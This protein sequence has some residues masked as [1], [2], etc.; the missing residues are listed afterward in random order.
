MK[1]SKNVKF[2]LLI[3]MTLVMFFSM[4]SNC[5]RT[6]PADDTYNLT[7]GI[8]GEG[9]V[10]PG[11]GTHKIARDT[12]VELTVN[13]S[14]GWEFDSWT[15]T[16]ADDVI[17]DGDIY[18][19]N[20]NSNKSITARFINGDSIDVTDFLVLTKGGHVTGVD[21]VSIGDPANILTKDINLLLEK[22]DD[23][24]SDV[25][26]PR[27]IDNSNIVSDFYELSADKFFTTDNNDDYLIIGIPVPDNVDPSNLG[28]AVLS[29]PGWVI[30]LEPVDPSINWSFLRGDYEE[31]TGI[32]W[33]LLPTLSTTDSPQVI[34]LVQAEWLSLPE[35]ETLSNLY[36]S[37][38][39]RVV[40]VGLSEDQSPPKHKK[41]T[42]DELENA[43]DSYLSFGFK[44]PRLRRIATE[45]NSDGYMFAGRYEYIHEHGNNH[46][47]F[48]RINTGQAGTIYS[49]DPQKPNKITAAHEL[50]HAVQ[51]A[52]SNFLKQRI[53]SD[54]MPTG[55]N[56]GTA[57]AAEQS[58]DGLTRSD[59]SNINFDSRDP[60]N[61]STKL[62][63]NIKSISGIALSSDYQTQDF[64]V[65]L[66]KKMNPNNPQLDYLV[67]LFERGGTK[68]DIDKWLAISNEF[69]GLSDAYWE[70]V[71]DYAFE[72]TIK[73]GTHEG[74]I[75][76]FGN[77]GEWWNLALGDKQDHKVK[78]T[79]EL[80]YLTGQA[81]EFTLKPLSSRAFVIELE[82]G[83]N[84][85][86]V[87]LDVAI[88]NN[89]MINYKFYDGTNENW[90]EDRDNKGRNYIVET[91]PI[92]IFVLVSNTSLESHSGNLMLIGYMRENDLFI[93]ST[94]PESPAELL[95]G[96]SVLF[97]FNYKTFW[98]NGIRIIGEP[99]L[100]G[101]LLDCEVQTSS[102]YYPEEGYGETSF[103]VNHPTQVNEIRFRMMDALGE[104]KRPLLEFF[105][106]VDFKFVHEKT[107]LFKDS[108]LEQ[109][110]IEA[111]GFEIGQPIYS[112]DAEQ[113]EELI[114]A[115]R[116]IKYLDGIEH[117]INLR[118][119]N[120]GD[121]QISD[122]SPIGSLKILENLNLNN[123]SLTDIS[124]LEFLRL[125]STMKKF[126]YFL[127]DLDISN[128]SIYD[129]SPLNKTISLESLNCAFNS[130][131]SVYEL[132]NLINLKYLNISNNDV[133]DIDPLIGLN[134]LEYFNFNNNGIECLCSFGIYAPKGDP[135]QINYPELKALHCA[136]NFIDDISPLQYQK[137]LKELDFSYNFV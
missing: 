81:I 135:Y 22:T 97:N 42:F 56:E 5:N 6:D 55:T 8:T 21:G 109:A 66:G 63:N 104:E 123:N 105:M 46:N 113:L 74:E 125:Y 91:A 54:E 20:M 64:W 128:N 12:T 28:F 85:Y 73:L 30:S 11:E 108:N 2:I 133:Y 121:N 106:P 131:I 110:V 10:N 38:N 82:P 37:D 70:W 58:L 71:K 129:L 103:T 134:K 13:A 87:I 130:I 126:D 94:N 98:Q 53:E 47:G 48:Y 120:L 23:P 50:F 124:I 115:N 75:V 19:I 9:S 76:P 3:V 61:I 35:M 18:K 25:P 15:G 27:F 90:I 78:F 114:A 112:S 93:V 39:F 92:E 89:N 72:K 69:S 62:F 17:E 88:D 1:L 99:F 51:Y 132:E 4:A 80:G 102:V 136:D 111:L 79:P 52:Y 59:K 45:I 127:T 119:L 33:T 68:K 7:I 40:R 101:E 32:F 14:E 49:G 83:T 43:L 67:D 137:H 107:I 96:E 16:N 60:I 29:P 24:S 31:D 84:F 122:I 95:L 65:Y 36:G 116:N 41:I 26:F 117:L 100:D 44:E 86:E 118:T 57:T 34:A 77:P